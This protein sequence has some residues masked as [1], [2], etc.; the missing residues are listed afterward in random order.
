MLLQ[1]RY[2][3][4]GEPCILLYLLIRPDIPT[5]DQDTHL[6]SLSQSIGRQHHMSLQINDE[7]EEQAGL[8]DALDSD[9]DRTGSQ[10]T[11]ARKTL[12]KVSRGARDNCTCR[13]STTQVPLVLRLP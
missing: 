12:D 9:L 2:I 3:M 4:Q 5:P 11:R 10:L 13:I 8:L 1:Q 6:E 7:L